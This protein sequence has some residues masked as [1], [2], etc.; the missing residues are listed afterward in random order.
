MQ[1]RRPVPAPCSEQRRHPRVRAQ[2][3]VVHRWWLGGGSRAVSGEK[4]CIGASTRTGRIPKAPCTRGRTLIG[5][6]RVSVTGRLRH[7]EE[8]PG[9]GRLRYRTVAALGRWHAQR[10]CTGR[11]PYRTV[12]ARA[13]TPH[14][15]RPVH[16]GEAFGSGR[17]RGRYRAPPVPDS[18]STRAMACA[19]AWVKGAS[20]TG[21]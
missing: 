5:S 20:S 19:E 6:A 3:R 12:P 17:R 10:P 9:T 16:M 11:L 1:R 4:I 13:L 8:R 21:H 2:H 18:C 15:R 14:A 7:F